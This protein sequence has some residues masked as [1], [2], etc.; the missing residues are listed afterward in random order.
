[1]CDLFFYRD[2]EE[3]EK[4]EQAK[5]EAEQHAAAD[6]WATLGPGLEGAPQQPPLLEPTEQW[7]DTAT[8]DWGA[9][10]S[11]APIIPGGQAAAVTTGGAAATTTPGF[12]ASDQDWNVGPTT[13]TKDWGADDTGDWGN[14]EPKATG[15][16]W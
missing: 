8:G 13:S 4:E 2:P 16:N 5:L 10:V 3:V 1:M 9:D 14:A 12:M 15:G 6:Q 7:A 11:T